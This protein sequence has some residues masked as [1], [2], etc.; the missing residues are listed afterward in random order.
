MTNSKNL[1]VCGSRDGYGEIAYELNTQIPKPK[2]THELEAPFIFFQK[3]NL[4]KSRRQRRE[5]QLSF[6][7]VNI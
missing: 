2:T 6:E 1:T 5:Q 7:T 4:N 3:I